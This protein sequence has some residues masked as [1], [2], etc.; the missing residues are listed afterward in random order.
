[1]GLGLSVGELVAHLGAGNSVWSAVGK[2][3]DI[4]RMVGPAFKDANLALS[5]YANM[6]DEEAA[7]L[8]AY[9][10]SEFDISDDTVEVAIESALKLVIQLHELAKLVVKP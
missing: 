7:G 6:T 9:V 3:V 4:G 5:E 8:E 1:M 2:V 10:V